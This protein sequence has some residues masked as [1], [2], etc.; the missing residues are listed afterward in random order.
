MSREEKMKAAQVEGSLCFGRDPD[1]PTWDVSS[2]TYP[3]WANIDGGAEGLLALLAARLH[4]CKWDDAMPNFRPMKDGEYTEK[5]IDRETF[6]LHLIDA[7]LPA[8][9]T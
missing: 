2:R 1:D 9:P 3:E 5:Y 4:G 7:L 6:V 8:S